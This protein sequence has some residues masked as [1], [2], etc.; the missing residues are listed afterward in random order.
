MSTFQPISWSE[1]PDECLGYFMSMG[2][3]SVVALGAVCIVFAVLAVW[4]RGTFLRRAVHFALFAILLSTAS[5]LFNA[6]W[7][8]LIWGHLYFSTDYLVDFF[9]FWPITQR[10]IDAE[11]GGMRGQLLGVSLFQ[12]QLVWLLFASG[13][14]TATILFYRICR[15]PPARGAGSCGRVDSHA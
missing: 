4:Q 11:F 1:F 13:T 6:L 7:S 8:C 9:P 15:Q 10:V 5:A 12:V 3:L 14:W 2:I